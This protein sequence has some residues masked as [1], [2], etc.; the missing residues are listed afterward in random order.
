MFNACSTSTS[1]ESGVKTQESSTVSGKFKVDT[2][3]STIKWSGS[4][5]TGKH[6]GKVEIESGTIA[7]LNGEIHGGNIFIDMRSIQAQDGSPEKAN[8]LSAHLKNADF[9]KVTTYPRATLHILSV[10]SGIMS[11]DLT[12]IDKTKTITFPATIS[13]TDTE[14]KGS[15]K[16][17]INRTDWGIFYGSGSFSDAV[18]DKI[19]AD[20]IQFEVTIVAKK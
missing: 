4:K 10:D 15:A 9:F 1:N 5:P 16:F 14:I 7:V 13:I 20:E 18:K 11:A 8:K 12:I 6:Y 2:A 17:E 19:I 3:F